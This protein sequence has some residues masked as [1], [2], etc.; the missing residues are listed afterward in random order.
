M[1]KHL[2]AIIGI[3]LIGIEF[4]PYIIGQWCP[5][6]E[7]ALMGIERTKGITEVGILGIAAPSNDINR[8][9]EGIRAKDNRHHSLID[10]DTVN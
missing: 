7:R 2:I 8:P 3:V 6:I 10:F 1:G 4:Y 5:Y 9:S